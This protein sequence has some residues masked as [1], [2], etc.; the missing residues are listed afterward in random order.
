M[1]IRIRI[2]GPIHANIVIGEYQQPGGTTYFDFWHV[3]TGASGFG[4][5]AGLGIAVPAGDGLRALGGVAGDAFA[6]V[7]C[8]IPHQRLVGVMA[9]D[10]ADSPISS[11]EAFA[12]LQP[13]RLKPDVALAPNAESYDGRPCAMT[14]S[15]EARDLL[16]GKLFQISG[17]RIIDPFDSIELVPECSSV[18]VLAGDARFELRKIKL[19]GSHG[20]ARMA[21]E[22]ISNLAMVELSP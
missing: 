13:V 4:N 16:A 14:L 9:S 21:T 12:I 8:V 10:A 20:S 7:T 17:S 6:V 1:L 22:A 2:S 19:A 15:T 5:R 11:V 3:A 18:T